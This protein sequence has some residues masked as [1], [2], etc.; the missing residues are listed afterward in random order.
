[1]RSGVVT[2]SEELQNVKQIFEQ[3]F[4]AQTHVCTLAHTL[5]VITLMTSSTPPAPP[6]THN[7]RSTAVVSPELCTQ[8]DISIV[9]YTHADITTHTHTHV[10]AQIIL[11]N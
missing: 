11:W 5:R 10:H 1:M 9:T 3:V 4:P 7:H 8:T 6:H 2:C